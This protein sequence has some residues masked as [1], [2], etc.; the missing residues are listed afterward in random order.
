M[1]E[2]LDSTG[3]ELLVGRYRAREAIA[4]RLGGRAVLAEDTKPARP[5]A[6]GAAPLVEVHLLPLEAAPQAAFDK[7]ARSI[8]ALAAVNDASVPRPLSVSWSAEALVLV[9]E[10]ADGRPLPDVLAD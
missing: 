6:D 3:E 8:D 1:G 5:A 9:C 2:A 4:P 7:V 10:H